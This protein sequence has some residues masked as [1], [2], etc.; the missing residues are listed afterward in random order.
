MP[1]RHRVRDL[2]LGSDPTVENAQHV[3]GGK[4]NKTMRLNEEAYQK[5][6]GGK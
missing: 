4:A 5:A 1:F 3:G 6:V 2:T